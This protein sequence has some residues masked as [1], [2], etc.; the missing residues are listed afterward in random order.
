MKSISR[1]FNAVATLAGSLEGLATL[2]DTFAGRM[3]QQIAVEVI[4]IEPA[5]LPAPGEA[6]AEPTS[7]RKS[8]AAS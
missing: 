8:K 3:R 5:Q 4:D 7:R 2:V 6:A 1:L